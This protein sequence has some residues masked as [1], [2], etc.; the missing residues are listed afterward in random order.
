LIRTDAERL[1]LDFVEETLFDPERLAAIEERYVSSRP[2]TVDLRPRIAELERQ[3]QQF[4]KAIGAG[5]YSLAISAALKAAEGEL[6]QLRRVSQ[7]HHPR[8]V[9]RASTEPL[10]QRVRR[11]RHRL[12]QGGE[13]ARGVLG[14]VF[15]D[16]IWLDVAPSGKHFYAIF[17]DGIRAAL[18]F[19]D[20]S[21]LSAFPI[22]ESGGGLRKV[23]NMVA[24]AGFINIR[25]K[26]ALR[27]AA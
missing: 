23:G 11:L 15:P 8:P 17:E 24:G 9:P 10:A 13:I 27:R 22:E 2:A 25:R 16:S 14:E 7:V 21:D 1:L 19:D 20:C 18:G 26:R 3:V 5:E 12:A 4:V 6:E